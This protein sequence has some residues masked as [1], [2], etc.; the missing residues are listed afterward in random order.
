MDLV[1]VL[2][3]VKILLDSCS[4]FIISLGLNT[5][6]SIQNGFLVNSLDIKYQIS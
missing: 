2:K 6:F 3:W 1:F 5:T 4:I